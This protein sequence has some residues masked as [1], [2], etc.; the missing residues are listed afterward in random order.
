M[1]HLHQ[2]SRS[3]RG[4]Q[5]PNN[6]NKNRSHMST[7]NNSRIPNI[8]TKRQKTIITLNSNPL[9][10]GMSDPHLGFRIHICKK[11]TKSD[12][13]TH[14]DLDICLLINNYL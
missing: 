10:L 14:I 4:L 1:E 11:S 9:I 6:K 13:W 12:F 2:D 8:I 5:M 3:K 7:E